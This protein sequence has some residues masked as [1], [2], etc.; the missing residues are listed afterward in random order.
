MSSAPASDKKKK[1]DSVSSSKKK[2]KRDHERTAVLSGLDTI[3]E[4]EDQDDEKEFSINDQLEK[5]SQDQDED[6][7]ESEPED[8]ETEEDVTLRDVVSALHNMQ[9][10][11]TDAIKSLDKRVQDLEVPRDLIKTGAFSTPKRKDDTSKSGK[12]KK[13][14]YK[15][16]LI[17]SVARSSKKVDWRKLYGK[18]DD[19]DGDDG[20]SS[21]SSSSDSDSGKSSHS[22]SGGKGDQGSNSS[23]QSYREAKGSK[24]PAPSGKLF[25]SLD[26]SEKSA[27]ATV[28]NVTRVEKEC[29][30]RIN[31]FKLATVCRAIKNIIE[32]QERENTVVKMTKVLST[33]CK[34]HII[35]KY[36]MEPG[37]IATMEMS[38]LFSIIAR[39]TK[40]HSKIKFYEELK[41]AL[42]HI[43]LMDWE[44]VNATNHEAFY[45]QQLSLAEDFMMVLKIM[46]QENKEYCPNVNDK[47]NGLIR[48]FRSFHSY[49]FWKF[50]WSSMKQ[51]YKR[52]QDFIDEYLDKS[53]QQYELSLA[54]SE[55]PYASNTLVSKSDDKVNNYYNKKRFINRSLNNYNS[56]SKDV[57]NN[58]SLH[59][60]YADDLD[61]SEGSDNDTWKNANAVASNK[62]LSKDESGDDDS[63]SA[64]SNEDTELVDKPLLDL[65]LAAFASHENTNKLDK[66]NLACLRKM[67]S[68]KCD[69]IDCPYGHRT[70]ILL[71]GA[72]DMKA[73]INAFISANRNSNKDS[74]SSSPYKILHKEKYGKA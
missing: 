52:M 41:E 54:L 74:S 47:E 45:F 9:D 57:S 18:E 8:D 69:N 60:L 58:E 37:D 70:D 7:Q 30:V 25:R 42:K 59:N 48:L 22:K 63:I 49:S 12:K 33:S 51:K 35:L 40:V 4:D 17:Q 46:L 38:T 68:G 6:D 64:A 65:N 66:K 62:Q 36:E 14:D 50:L 61:S 72:E 34:E 10:V 11:F 28:V 31:N 19:N 55:V 3:S 67:L 44:K 13:S 1:K 73:K 2:K 16:T 23:R 43:K 71:K 5:E 27:A 21:S 53:M 20:D 56:K 32:F 29:N 26:A 39:E 24:T 15:L